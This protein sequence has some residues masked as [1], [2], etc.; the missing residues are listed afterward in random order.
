ML[1]NVIEEQASHASILSPS[2][3][4]SNINLSNEIM[5]RRL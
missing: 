2:L 4:L 5:F 3:K 1:Y